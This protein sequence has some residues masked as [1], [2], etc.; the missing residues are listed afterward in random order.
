MA[1]THTLIDFW[2]CR[3][4]T[5]AEW[6]TL[7][8]SVV[9]AAG[10][11]LLELRVQEFEPQGLTAFCLLSESHLSVHTWPETGYVG[12]D[13]FTCG[14]NCRPEKA[15]ELLNDFLQPETS[16]VRS[17]ELVVFPAGKSNAGSLQ[18]K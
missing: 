13:V 6:D 3:E 10:V 2:N 18:A 17:L 15:V 1:G 14:E 8:R 7:L 11:Q 16:H 9:A 5:P 12:I 4:C